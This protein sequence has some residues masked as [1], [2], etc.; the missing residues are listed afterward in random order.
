MSQHGSFKED[1]ES[2]TERIPFAA[3]W[4]NRKAANG[5]F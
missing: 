1:I 5:I 4:D 2:R 3:G